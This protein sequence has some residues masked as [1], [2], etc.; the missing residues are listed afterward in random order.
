MYAWK[1]K[2]QPHAVFFS[3]QN[4]RI[5][6]TPVTYSRH[7]PPAKYLRILTINLAVIND[8]F[9]K[10]N[11][12]YFEHRDHNLWKYCVISVLIKLFHVCAWDDDKAAW[13]DLISTVTALTYINAVRYRFY[14][15]SSSTRI[16][17]VVAPRK[18]IEDTFNHSIIIDYWS[19]SIGEMPS[20]MWNAKCK[21]KP[22]RKQNNVASAKLIQLVQAKLVCVKLTQWL[23]SCPSK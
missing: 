4:F 16:C 11:I 12:R 10:V 15:N 8:S 20:T 18:Q 6:Q 3:G 17:T 13:L 1:P 2:L 9:L 7:V 22:T 19:S 21:K 23:D 14:S 5:S